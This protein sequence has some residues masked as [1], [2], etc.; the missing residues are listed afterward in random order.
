MG[1]ACGDTNPESLATASEIPHES[2]ERFRL[3]MES[4]KEYA[5]FMVDPAR[6]VSLASRRSRAT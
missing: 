6:I 3:L 1:L 4:V 2:V 5:I